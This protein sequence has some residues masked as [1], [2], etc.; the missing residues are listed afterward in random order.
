MA[1]SAGITSNGSGSRENHR[2]RS[3]ESGFEG[4]DR[5]PGLGG[6]VSE[7]VADAQEA[8]GA[9]RDQILLG[10]AGLAVGTAMAVAL[11]RRRE[12]DQGP[13]RPEENTERRAVRNIPVPYPSQSLE[14]P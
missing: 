5:R 11:Q 14:N 4:V 12:A 1:A 2:S 7:I 6:S 8:V 9:S 10:V 3:V 13:Y